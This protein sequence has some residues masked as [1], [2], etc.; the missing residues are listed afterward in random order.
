MQSSSPTP[1]NHRGLHC[2]RPNLALRAGALSVNSTN[3][4]HG[5]A[6]PTGVSSHPLQSRP[7]QSAAT[8]S[9]TPCCKPS[10]P[11]IHGPKL[12]TFAGEHAR[13]CPWK[14]GWPK[15]ADVV[16][17]RHSLPRDH[18]TAAGATYSSDLLA[19]VESSIV[20]NRHTGHF[21]RIW[22]IWRIWRAAKPP[23]PT[24]R[25]ERRA[26]HVLSPRASGCRWPRVEVELFRAGSQAAQAAH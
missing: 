21:W 10:R 14:M 23:Q 13:G 24:G 17:H 8:G 19:K 25:N 4:C 22:R 7:P 5:Y 3:A 6:L 26:M 9:P 2:R 20:P 15:P 11:A 18:T 16:T 12:Q 1:Q